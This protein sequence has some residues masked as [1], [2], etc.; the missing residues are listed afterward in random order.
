ML[1]L[2]ESIKSI[3]ERLG[4]NAAPVIIPIGLEHEHRG[5]VDLVTMK[6]LTYKDVEDNKLT[7]EEIPADLIEMAKKYRRELNRKS[8]LSLM[9]KL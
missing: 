8:L 4:A 7:E 6:A 1:I 5:V 3:H 2:K 9:T